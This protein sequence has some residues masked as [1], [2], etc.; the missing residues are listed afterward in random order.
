MNDELLLPYP[1]SSQTLLCAQNNV[2]F[3]QTA[4]H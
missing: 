3:L 2:C 1:G 4:M